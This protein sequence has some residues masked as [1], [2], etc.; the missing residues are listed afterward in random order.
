[1][2]SVPILLS[3]LLSLAGVFRQGDAKAAVAGTGTYVVSIDTYDDDPWYINGALYW[4]NETRDVFGRTVNL[5]TS[6]IGTGI[7][8]ILSPTTGSY[9]G[10]TSGND[11]LLRFDMVN[12][13]YVT[14]GATPPF[15]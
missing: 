11:D 9:F 10:L 4:N 7:P 5:G 8:A 6:A 13:A 1:M 12:G 14:Y 2:Q 15:G 3:A